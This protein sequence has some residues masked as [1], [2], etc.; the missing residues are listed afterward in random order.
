[1]HKSHQLQDERQYS[2]AKLDK[3]RTSTQIQELAAEVGQDPAKP[4][5]PSHAG[6]KTEFPKFFGDR[7]KFTTCEVHI[8]FKHFTTSKCLL[9][10]LNSPRRKCRT[11]V[12]LCQHNVARRI[13]YHLGYSMLS[14]LKVP[15]SRST[16]SSHNASIRP[17][18]IWGQS[19]R[20]RQR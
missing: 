15:S 9:S 12:S 10:V 13:V 16:R 5:A 7:G 1:M 3:L 17:L 4:T 11:E 19:Q 8:S 6:E 20:R 2:R 14:Q 18:Q